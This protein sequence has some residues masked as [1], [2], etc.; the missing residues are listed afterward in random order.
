MVTG[1]YTDA[2]QHIMSL[3]E[4]AKCRKYGQQAEFSHH[5]TLSMPSNGSALHICGSISVARATRRAPTIS[6][7]YNRRICG[8]SAWGD[9]SSP[10][11]FSMQYNTKLWRKTSSVF[12]NSGP[13]PCYGLI[14]TSVGE[15]T[16]IK[17]SRLIMCFRYC[18]VGG[19]VIKMCK[20][21]IT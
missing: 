17:N 21:Y 2:H 1:L 11:F 15:R 3:S 8:L 19:G 20:K 7:V 4:S 12:Q 5:K 14:P 10:P 13:V 18:S 6:G 16:K 9:W